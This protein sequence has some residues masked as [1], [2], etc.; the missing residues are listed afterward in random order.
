MSD[1]FAPI[2]DGKP[3]GH[4][5]PPAAPQWTLIAP[6]PPDAASPPARHPKLGAPSQTW[7]YRAATG[8]ALGYVLRFD[9]ADG[10]QFRPLALYAPA[11]GGAPVW[12]WEAWPAPRPLYGLDRL[13][14]RP[15]AFVVVS[16]GEKSADAATRLLPDFVCVTSPNGSKSAAKADWSPLRGRDVTIWRDADEPGLEYARK[17]AEL[18]HAAGAASVAIVAPPHGVAP[19]WDAADAEAEGW[20]P[21]RALDLVGAAEPVERPAANG[22]KKG[23]QKKERRARQRDVFM[24]LTRDCILWH[25]PD[26]EGFVTFPVKDHWETWPLR[27]G[28]FRRWLSSRAYE[29]HG[30]VPGGQALEDVTRVLEARAVSEGE[31][32]APW[33]RVGA[34]DG[35]LYIDLADSEW[36]VVKITAT[37]REL[38]AAH[39]S[40]FVRS[41]RMRALCAP[42]GGYSIG[43]ILGPFANVAR[44]NPLGDIAK[45]HDFILVVAWLVASFRERGPYPILVLNGEQGSGKSSFA[46]RLRSLLDP[47]SPPI[48]G[49]PKDEQALIVTAQNSHLIAFD[50]LSHISPELSDGLC[51]L[52]TGGGFAIRALHTDKDENIFDGARPVIING[53]PSLADRPDLNQRAIIVRLATIPEDM[54]LPEDELDAKWEEAR[55]YVLGAICAALSSALRNIGKTK[56]ARYERM[57]DLQKWVAAAEPGLGWEPGTFSRAYA[58]NCRDNAEAAFEG[59][60]VAVAIRDF[61]LQEYSYFWSGTATEL[62]NKLGLV[63]GET[64]RQMRVWPKTAQALGNCIERCAPLLRG[65]GITIERKHSGVRHINISRERESDA[66]APR[67]DD[68]P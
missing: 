8:G 32:R 46:R 34:R 39:D 23:K 5:P 50:N 56:L 65:K 7:T 13:A 44:A 10:K 36:R 67:G 19:G 53:I 2:G 22:A 9:G 38:L 59:D 17:V 45:E 21:A 42:L 66:P 47:S 37:G 31:Q 25:G 62:L 41:P 57:A 35:C 16:E 30:V 33:R 58:S 43:D 52:S 12:R 3:N 48:Q 1:P 61:M 40:P 55:P 63:V 27:S 11:G 26:Y 18:C 64:T 29:A 60:I 24:E 49:P 4:A 14:E 28:A 15:S 20:T 54:R 51:R 68:F 6:A